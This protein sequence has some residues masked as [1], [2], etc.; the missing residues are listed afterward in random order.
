V[1][2]STR[3]LT[4]HAPPAAIWPW[5]VQLGQGRGGFYSYEWLENLFAAGVHNADRIIPELQ[6]L[7]VGDHLSFQRDGPFAVVAAIDPENALVL[8]G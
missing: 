3:A 6:Q 8:E 7:Q 1:W 2:N 5:L 4:V